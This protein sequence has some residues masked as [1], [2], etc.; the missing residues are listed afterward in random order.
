MRGPVESRH[1]RNYIMSVVERATSESR[2][3]VLPEL[4][5]PATRRRGDSPNPVLALAAGLR[6]VMFDPRL[7][8]GLLLIVGGAVWALT[9]GL[10]FYGASPVN[11][12]YDLDQPPVLLAI[13]GAW[14]MYRSRRR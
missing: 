3:A 12:A 5:N 6:R 11:I 4:V 8:V 1:A 14:F 13:V 10:E 9:R 7:L 2:E